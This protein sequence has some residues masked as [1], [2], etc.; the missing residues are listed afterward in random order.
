MA[1]EIP[2][3]SP[4]QVDLAPASMRPGRMAAEMSSGGGIGQEKARL[5]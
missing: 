1:A 2:A 3:A 5:Q 4:R